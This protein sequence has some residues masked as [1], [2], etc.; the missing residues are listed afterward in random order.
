MP[1]T[2]FDLGAL[3][4]TS[5]EV[6]LFGGF[7]SGAKDDCYIYKTGPDDGSFTDGK[8]LATPDF[9]VQNG[10]YIKVPSEKTQFIFN[11]HNHMHLF[12]QDTMEFKTL[13][14]Q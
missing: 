6:L 8:K 12:D 3:Q 4:I 1:K 14:M 2:I 13:P 7:D 11:G 5:N 10:V 9:F